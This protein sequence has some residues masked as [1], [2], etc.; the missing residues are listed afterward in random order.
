MTTSGSL[1]ASAI[2][3]HLELKRRNQHLDDR[4]SAGGVPGRRPVRQPPA[5]Q[6]RGGRASRGGGDR[7]APRRPRDP[8]RTPRSMPGGRRRQPAARVDGDHPGHRI[9]LG[10]D[11]RL[12]RPGHE[13]HA[14]HMDELAAVIRP[15]EAP[16]DRYLNRELSWLDW[17][18]RVPRAGRGRVVPLLERVRLCSIVAADA[19]RVLHDPGGRPRG[20][21]RGRARRSLGRRA[22]AAVA[23]AEIRS[24][25]SRCGRARSSC[26]RTSW[27]RALRAEGIQIGT[28]ED[29][30][31]DERRRSAS[32]STARST[33][34]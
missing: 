9:L 31:A 22:H 4:S 11:P 27:C 19:R 26:G 20:P 34:C 30:T 2:E 6:D 5:V 23:L 29:C 28:F 24:A 13:G 1:F 14:R 21:D 17:D 16:G 10:V 25:S 33:R 3:H 32:G 12:R 18:A 15:P 7:R 8:G